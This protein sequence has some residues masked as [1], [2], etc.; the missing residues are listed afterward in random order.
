MDS[1][2]RDLLIRIAKMYFLE[3][4]TQQQI[5]DVLQISRSN[6]S[7]YLQQSREEKI[8]E[9]RI[10]DTSSTGL[11]HQDVLRNTF[12]LRDVIVVGSEPELDATKRKVGDAGAGLLRSLLEPGM[13]IGITIGTT[14]YS[15]VTQIEPVAQSMD[16]EVVELI[17]GSGRIDLSIE[18]DE[19]A[20]TLAR[21]LRAARHV[22]QAPAIVRDPGLKRMLEVEPEVQRV[23]A[24]A[25]KVDVALFGVGVVSYDETQ[26]Y[27]NGHLT[28]EELSA[29]IED[30]AA[31]MLCGRL[32]KEDGSVLDAEI[33]E[34]VIGLELQ[35]LR[36]V[37]VR[38]CVAAGH[39]KA[40]PILSALRGGYVDYLVTDED[41]ALHIQSLLKYS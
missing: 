36:R 22:I 15:V 1:T 6:V 20:F 26:Y 8:V 10:N 14:V 5:A 25:E 41:A 2:K 23:L 35:A 16:L 4:L 38:I 12:S 9:I 37:P 30:G 17:G 27:K 28:R 29:M 40:R 21:K 18:G 13:H 32:L 11:R 33:H 24:R 19:I 3:G 39:H 34:R 7:N 31:G